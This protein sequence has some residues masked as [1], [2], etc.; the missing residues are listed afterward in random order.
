[1]EELTGTPK[2]HELEL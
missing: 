1:M 2:V